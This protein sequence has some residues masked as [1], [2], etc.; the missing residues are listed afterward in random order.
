M[1]F[2][3]PVGGRT[4]TAASVVARFSALVFS[5]NLLLGPGANSA[6]AQAAQSDTETLPILVVTP[7]RS[8]LAL[9]R[10]GSAV[11]V[12]GRQQI[13]SWGSKSVAD[14]LRGNAGVDIAENGGP[15]SVSNLSLRGSSPGQ[16]LVLLD[17]IR[18]G[19]PSNIDGSFDF[20]AFSADNVERIEI[21]RGP[22]SALYGS[23]AMGGVVN[24]ITRKGTG[25]PKTILTFEAG[26]HGTVSSSLS[27]FGTVKKFSYAF[28]IQGFHTDGFSRYG[29]RIG[30]IASQFPNGLE[31]DKTDKAGASARIS[32]RPTGDTEI[33]IGFRTFANTFRFD[34]PF[35]FPVSAKD[36][37][38]N[39]GR[40]RNLIG[41][42]KFVH[43]IFDGRLKNSI[44]IFASKTNRFNRLEQSC[45]DAIFNSYDCEVKF[46]SQRT[47]IEYQG[48]LKLGRYGLF[49]FGAR[50]EKEQARGIE[51]W[52]NPLA[53]SIPTF[54]GSQTT[55]SV[56]GL[57]QFSL[58]AL[59]ISIGG[60]VDSVQ[61]ENTFPTW[62][63]TIAYRIPQTGTKIRASAGTGAK[64]PTL[65]QR[66]SIYGSPGLQAET[67]LS[68]DVGI[69]QSLW[70]G[71]A[72]FSLTAFNSRYQ[73]LIGFNP[74]LNAGIGGYY[75]VG[76]A[77]T[78]G[79]EVSAKIIIVPETW[80]LRASYTYLLATDEIT[81]L[82]LLRRPKHKG[83]VSLVYSGIPKLNAE[84]R[85]TF[86]G[87]RLDI[88][89]D[90]PF[91]RVRMAPFAKL[92]GRISYKLSDKV[93]LFARVENITDAR[94]Q[95]I[96]D[97]GVVGRS[98]YA[99]A[100]I[101]W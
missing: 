52:I 42:A 95:E 98:F 66:F 38:L 37:R 24:I 62:R 99:G 87:S 39:K 49:V 73:N 50:L 31:R 58:G 29:Y 55:N 2:N 93:T 22:Q 91:S 61:N 17:G 44:H 68:F 48:D 4:G 67:N 88:S 19:D 23:D 30:R 45:F 85:I 40:Q 20:G 34:N 35:A 89:N 8:P 65:Y 90:F 9:N 96:R 86:I 10:S 57:H 21:L 69:D 5:C 33:T 59:D 100:K 43:T 101:V 60:R 72:M 64:T 84:A 25:K 32:Y 27:T 36:T 11:T 94:Y 1:S 26:S 77:K 54:K 56:F 7:Y 18:I 6:H 14:I 80:R 53:P 71:R 51:Q 81:T 28:S 12:I 41:Y 13:E 83:F 79:V 46:Q 92:D 16:T 97:Y 78:Q 82:Q 76:R 3:S 15:G 74:L 47:G 75:N 63:T 70:N